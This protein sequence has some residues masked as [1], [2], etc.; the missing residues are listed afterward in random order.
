MDG[1]IRQFRKEDGSYASA[2]FS[3]R[4]INGIPLTIIDVTGFFTTGN[5]T[6]AAGSSKADYRML[7]AVAETEAGP[8]IFKL[9]GPANTVGGWEPS[10]QSFLDT[11]E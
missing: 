1:W 10:F 8:W 4:E 11:I 6:S 5:G 7:A 9:I 2:D 3:R